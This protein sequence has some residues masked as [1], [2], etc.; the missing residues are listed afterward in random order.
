MSIIKDTV[1][2][3]FFGVVYYFLIDKLVYT[4][5]ENTFESNKYQKILI[6]VFVIG[7]V[8]LLLSLSIL[9]KNRYFG[10]RPVRYGLMLGSAMLIFYSIISNWSKIDDYTKIIVFAIV[11]T[12]IIWFSYNNSFGETVSRVSKKKERK[13]I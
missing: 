6:T 13:I 9:Q 2:A 1:L 12:S 10:N 8:G 3:L 4:I 11:L 5:V 7:L